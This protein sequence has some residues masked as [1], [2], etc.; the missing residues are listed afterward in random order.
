MT[1]P[2]PAEMPSPEDI[3]A[4]QDLGDQQSAREAIAAAPDDETRRRIL[5]RLWSCGRLAQRPNRPQ[6][7]AEAAYGEGVS[8][9]RIGDAA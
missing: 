7:Y 1:P 2:D 9:R 4:M 8:W 5:R 6:Q 3:I